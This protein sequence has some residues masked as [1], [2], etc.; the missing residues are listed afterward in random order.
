M[1]Q[2][3]VMKLETQDAVFEIIMRAIRKRTN[4]KGLPLAEVIPL[5]LVKLVMSKHKEVDAKEKALKELG[6]LFTRPLKAGEF[7]ARLLVLV[8]DWKNGTPSEEELFL[9]ADEFLKHFGIVGDEGDD[10]FSGTLS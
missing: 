1:Q 8:G 3:Y 2:I 9:F 5:E 10:S 7:L 6:V 4:A